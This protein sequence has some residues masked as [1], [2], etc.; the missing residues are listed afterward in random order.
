MSKQNR[1]K[2]IVLRHIV[3][4]ASP[5]KKH[6]LLH[7][8]AN[9][10]TNPATLEISPK[11]QS[12]HNTSHSAATRQPLTYFGYSSHHLTPS[13]TIVTQDLRVSGLQ[14]FS[15]ATPIESALCAGAMA[16]SLVRRCPLFWV[17]AQHLYIEGIHHVW[18]NKPSYRTT[19]I[20]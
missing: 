7:N 4:L 15:P 18:G 2:C 19:H 13:V 17:G 16:S 10:A 5:T 3:T 1:Q 20:F 11:R 8:P 12:F 6:E 9:N 14:I